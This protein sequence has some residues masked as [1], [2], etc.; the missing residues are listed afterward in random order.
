MVQAQAVIDRR[1]RIQG[2]YD[3]VD[4]ARRPEEGRYV[5][6]FIEPY[7]FIPLTPFILNAA[8][9]PFVYVKRDALSGT[10][11][12]SPWGIRFRGLFTYSGY[13]FYLGSLNFPTD[14]DAVFKRETVVEPQENQEFE[15]VPGVMKLNIYVRFAMT[16]PQRDA[17]DLG[18]KRP[19]RELAPE[20]INF[21]TRYRETQEG[22][23][24]AVAGLITRVRNL[25]LERA[26]EKYTV[27]LAQ[28]NLEDDIRKELPKLNREFGRRLN[29]HVDDITAEINYTPEI[30]KE[31]E[32][33]EVIVASA[34]ARRRAATLQAEAYGTQ[35]DAFR[36]RGLEGGALARA[37]EA[38]VTSAAR[39]E[40]SENMAEGIR[41][42]RA[43]PLIS[44]PSE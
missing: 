33:A 5:E 7:S 22:L 30:M 42:S 8:S 21:I 24:E 25:A 15:A 23:S 32:Q 2:L 1:Q 40:W 19:V 26:R 3:I 44:I 10:Y 14:I 38:A 6:R 28:K 35:L 31:L 27:P 37:F 41:Q 16:K 34:T 20:I 11:S 18:D 43:S 12:A 4:R 17:I 9:A 39:T 13:K 36:Q 29:L